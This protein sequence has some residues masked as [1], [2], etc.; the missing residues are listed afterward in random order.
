MK[1][2]IFMACLLGILSVTTKIYGSTPKTHPG[3]DNTIIKFMTGIATSDYKK[4]DE[5]LAENLFLKVPHLDKVMTYNKSTMLHDIKLRNGMQENFKTNYVV[6]EECDAFAIV[7]IDF[8]YGDSVMRN[9]I[10]LENN[11]EK[12][13]KITQVYESFKTIN[14]SNPTDGVIARK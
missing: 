3:L 11:A 4:L 14:R 1:S 12:E 5:V 9:F 7:Q 8:N 2:K 10:V 13:W 6:L